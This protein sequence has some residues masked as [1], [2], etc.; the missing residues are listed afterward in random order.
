MVNS[1]IY[2]TEIKRKSKASTVNF[3]GNAAGYLHSQAKIHFS[4][5]NSQFQPS[6]YRAMHAKIIIIV[7][8]AC[9]LFQ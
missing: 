3:F 2:F 6:R 7:V 8:Y 4:P 9:I 1:L 5:P